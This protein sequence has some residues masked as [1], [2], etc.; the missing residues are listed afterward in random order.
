VK[1]RAF[2]ATIAVIVGLV[3]F[4]ATTSS[5]NSDR[6]VRASSEEVQAYAA[7]RYIVTT[8]RNVTPAALLNGHPGVRSKARTFRSA[9]RGFVAD[10][11]AEEANSLIND[12]QVL[13]VEPDQIIR[14]EASQS[15]DTL[16]PPMVLMC[17]SMWW[18]LPSVLRIRSFL[19]V[20]HLESCQAS[21]M[22]IR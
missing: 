3:T 8:R 6:S 18:T 16:L 10:L 14:V 21:Q 22:V 20:H 12:P 5:A 15:R 4:S 9:I 7:G 1:L 17:T 19:R 11:T 13:S 2:A